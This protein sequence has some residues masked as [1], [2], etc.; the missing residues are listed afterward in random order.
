MKTRRNQEGNDN[1][2]LEK[3][4]VSMMNTNCY[5]FYDEVIKEAM[6]I[7]PG[8]RSER[9]LEFI[10]QKELK[11][12]YIYLT[13]CHFDHISGAEWLKENVGGEIVILEAE[14]DNLKDVDVNLSVIVVGKA[15]S[16]EA[17]KVVFE[18][19]ELV[20]GNDV[21]KVIHTAGHTSGGSCLYN[22]EILFAGDTLFLGTHGRTDLPTSNYSDII[23]SIKT[24]L[25]TLPDNILVYPGHG[26]STT[27]GAEREL[28]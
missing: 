8:D 21:F 26:N 7:D 3:F 14:K 17:D 6:V 16:L 22:G 2:V 1:I 5:V 18:G 13:H 23:N 27:I 11:I 24:K 28:Y 12:K 9:L 19:D 25:L 15:V 4:Y 20:V 10:Q